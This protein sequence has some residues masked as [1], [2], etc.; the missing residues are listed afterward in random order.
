MRPWLKLSLILLL[1]F[2]LS[3]CQNDE[4]TPTVTEV[5]QVQEEE[6][7]TIAPTETA[8]LPTATSV[9]TT[10]AEPTATAELAYEP[11]FEAGDCEFSQPPGYDVDCGWLIVPED[12]ANPEKTIRL[13]V[14]VFH[15]NNP[16]PDPIVY[17][18]GGPGGDA[19]ETVPLVFELRFAPFLENHDLIMFDQRGTGYSQPS[20]A[21]PEV[22]E[23]SF[24][25]MEQD[26]TPE[27]VLDQSLDAV[28]ACQARLIED[29]VNLGA[30]NSRESAADL[31]DLR[32]TLGY[33]SWNVWGISY[34]TRL[35]QTVMRDYP[36]GI[37]S[38]VLDST[39]PLSANLLTDTPDNVMRAFEVF[40]AGCE[41]DTACNETYPELETVFL[42]LVVQLDA[43][44][45][46]LS[47]TNLFTGE[48]YEVMFRGTDLVGVLFQSLYAT[49]IIPVLPQMIFDIAAADYT[50]LTTLLSSFLANA[51]FISLGM[52]FSVQCHEENLFTTVEEVDAAAAEHPLLEPFFLT[53]PNL[54]PSALTVC[55]RWGAGQAEAIENEAIRSDIP[56]LIL[57]GEYDPITPPEWGQAVAADLPN[58]TYLV[59]PGVGHGASLAGECPISVMESFWADPASEPRVGCIATMGSPEFVA[60]D[61]TVTLIP[62]EDTTFGLTGVLPEGWQEAGPGVY[63]RGSNALDPTVLIQQA[64]PDMG[65]EA[66]LQLLSGQLGLTEAPESIETVT[67]G[68]YTWTFYQT[69]AQGAVVDIALTESEGTTIIVVLFSSEDEHDALTEAILLPVL[70]A[71]LIQ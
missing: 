68:A 16:Q 32:L 14:A 7:P 52:Q 5:A 43:E 65:A 42:D 63:A 2:A 37:R 12:R 59:F 51:D 39:Y 58:S 71:I 25:L 57:A 6:S 29:G 30:Y 9:P 4:P 41:A 23:V 20:L 10:P 17:L 28:Y 54:G 11:A 27:E 70:E 13:H 36:E 31:N 15:S 45:I 21:C 66:L 50:L 19:L 35:A 8:E 46:G 49:E 61:V 34:G 47:L 62:Y 48:R 56:T 3:A 67:V 40:F 22:T 18:E 44:P 24:A 1:I 38:V 64:V 33:E 55:D 69:E 60:A 26:V 53:S